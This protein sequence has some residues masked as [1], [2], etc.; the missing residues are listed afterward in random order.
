MPDIE[1]LVLWNALSTG[2]FPKLIT[3]GIEVDHF[4]DEDVQ[5]VYEY[6][7]NFMREY[8]QPPS[9]SAV[10]DQFP[11]FKAKLTGDPLDLHLKKFIRQVKYR[12]ATE[13][14]RAYH[15][16][17]DD[18]D[19]IDEIELRAIEMGR[20]LTEIVPAPK[21]H[22]LSEGLARKREYDRR[23]KEGIR[24]GIM[25]GI[26]SFDIITLGIQPHELVVIAG[27]MGMGKTTFMQL[28]ALNAYL[29][30]KTVLFISL[31]VEAEMILRKFDVMLSNVRYRALK[32]LEL[33]AGEEETW[34]K[35]LKQCEADKLERDIII[36]D[37]IANCT[38]DKVSAEIIREKP[39]LT[40]VDYLEEMRAP[41]GV[42]GW[43]AISQNGRDL[44]QMA[45]VMKNPII[46]ATQLN[47]D[48]GKGDVNLS[49]LGYQSIG[50]QAHTLIGLSQTEEQLEADEME[51]SLLKYRDG[52]SKKTVLL[53]WKMETMELGEK[54]AAQSFP[55]RATK[56]RLTKS[57]RQ[58]ERKLQLVQQTKDKENPFS[59]RATLTGLAALKERKAA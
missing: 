45:R 49:T 59:K 5:D 36:K 37:D 54:G 57:E 55:M 53:D 40:C 52:P 44:A 25:M 14:V 39:E 27:Y 47:R 7:M 50:K 19:E 30:G 56:K 22:R 17:L 11:K 58:A 43:E 10:K 2:E 23:K 16:A 18:P 21:S 26:P 48:G 42:I 38:P 6:C 3:R 34:T 20:E 41:R 46:T 1:R 32:A 24:H 28:L 35:I 29:Q 51:A 8:S 13:L 33:N 4:A 12:K 9:I 31:E 15:E